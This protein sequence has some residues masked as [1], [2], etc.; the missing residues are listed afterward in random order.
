MS[1]DEI[2][3]Q[4]VWLG[5]DLEAAKK[6]LAHLREKA[7][8]HGS[9]TVQSPECLQRNSEHQ[10]NEVESLS[11]NYF[12]CLDRDKTLELA[13]EIRQASCLVLDLETRIRRL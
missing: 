6:H 9:V 12:E 1:A 2:K 3:E 11:D 13:E 10:G 4:N 5:I 8:R 7:Y